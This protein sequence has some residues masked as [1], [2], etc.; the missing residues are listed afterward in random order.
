MS[1]F[2]MKPVSQV[3]AATYEAGK[4]MLQ[5]GDKG[6]VECG[7]RR[8]NIS[9]LDTAR[10]RLAV[11]CLATTTTIPTPTKSLS[12]TSTSSPVQPTVVV[13]PTGVVPTPTVVVGGGV[14]S[15]V[16]FASLDARLVG[17]WPVG[18]ANANPSVTGC[19][20]AEHDRYSSVGPDGRKYRSWHPITVWIDNTKDALYMNGS[21][22]DNYITKPIKAGTSGSCSF[23][24][25]HGEPP[26]AIAKPDLVGIAPLPA[27]GFTNIAEGRAK[28][29]PHA[30]FKVFTH[31]G[32][33]QSGWRVH[34]T[35]GGQNP[36]QPTPADWDMQVVVHQ[37]APSAN[38][39]CISAEI[40]GG[41]CDQNAELAAGATRIFQQFHEFQWWGRNPAG[42][43]TDVR[44]SA[45]TGQAIGKS[46]GDNSGAGR[47]IVDKQSPAYEIWNFVGKV[48]GVWNSFTRSFVLGPLDYFDGTISQNSNGQAVVSSGRF[49]SAQATICGTGAVFSECPTVPYGSWKTPAYG[50][51]GTMR[52]FD[53]TE[54]SWSNQN[55]N[56]FYC[57]DSRGNL[58][59]MSLCDANR[60]GFIKQRV[61]K[62]NMSVPNTSGWT[63]NSNSP[64]GWYSRMF[65]DDR[66]PV[67]IPMGN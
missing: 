22:A 31:L 17:G 35:T 66:M 33:N 61:A 5:G 23:G 37:G 11:D 9:W 57:T 64:S 2:E 8:L 18:H 45:D 51:I 43:I 38:S 56:E 6:I 15:S 50:Y 32:N 41:T 16:S 12:P 65:P 36:F 47:T 34:E 49:R 46:V 29:E 44:L 4:L 21:N 42:L 10:K 52:G 60:D 19:T 14:S 53:V 63:R 39:P 7:G 24:H 28:L 25:E 58:Q 54:W 3:L 55:G 62:L 13:L 40:D 59:D 48:G 67:G 1:G 27:F 26:L 20:A 30:G